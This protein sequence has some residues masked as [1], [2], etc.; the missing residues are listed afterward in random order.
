MSDGMYELHWLIG[1]GVGAL[2]LGA[3]IGLALGRTLIRSRKTKD[4]EA[5]LETA[6]TAL[7]DYRAEVYDQFAE[8]ARKFETLNESYHELHRH[9]ANSANVLLGE[10]ISTPLLRG[11]A[12]AEPAEPAPASNAEAEPV[13]EPVA[14]EAAQAEPMPHA[15]AADATE[16]N[17]TAEPIAD[18][19]PVVVTED[20][21]NEPAK[22]PTNTQKASA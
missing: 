7:R 16:P 19:D 8:T 1:V 14:T 21:S 15:A 3:I 11:P 6:E 10:G 18:A 17:L 22:A 5:S 9:L 12:E 13:P 4:L 20:S 2:L